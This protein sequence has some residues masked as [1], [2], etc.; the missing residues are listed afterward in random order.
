MWKS[1]LRSLGS[2]VLSTNRAGSSDEKRPLEHLWSIGMYVGKSPLQLGPS[3]DFKNPVFTRG[4]VTA[5]RAAFVADPFMIKVGDQ[6]HMFFEVW[7]SRSRKGEIGLAT[8]PN[9]LEW[10]HQK[11]VLA[12]PFHLSYPYVFESNG[13]HYMVPESCQAGAI[14]LYR[15]NRFPEEWTFAGDLLSGPYFADASLFQFQRKWWLFTETNPD[16]KHDT[17]RLYHSNNLLGPWEEHPKSPIVS[18]NGHTARPAGRVLVLGETIIRYAQDCDP[19]YGKQVFAFEVTCLTDSE[20]QERPIE[21]SP[22]LGASGSG[23]N[24]SGMHHVDAHL[25]P[26]GT[27]IACVD[28]WRGVATLSAD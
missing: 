17:L 10:T 24:Q 8:S 6:W 26:D 15:A 1:W 5:I 2:R 20:Y 28:G 11:I 3:A 13:E 27:W 18:G 16:V 12:E 14:R 9:A 25:L 19:V 7:N 22:M 23:W 4:N 21:K